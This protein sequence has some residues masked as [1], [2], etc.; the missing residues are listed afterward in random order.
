MKYLFN[1]SFIFCFTS[2]L[3]QSRDSLTFD[4]YNSSVKLYAIG[5]DHFEDDVQLQISIIEYLQKNTTIDVFIFEYSVEVGAIFNEYVLYGNKKEKVDEICSLLHENVS[6]KTKILL[7]FLK[8]YNLSSSHKI[9]VRG[10]DMFRFYELKRQMSGLLLIFPELSQINLPAV[11]RYVVKQ[12]VRNYNRKKSS[13]LINTLITEIEQHRSLYYQYLGKKMVD[14]EECL[15]DLKFYY[16]DYSWRKSDSIREAFMSQ[17]LINIVDSNS[18]SV[19]ICGGAHAMFKENDSWYY[20][21]P[22]SS[23]VAVA[24]GK[25]PNQVYSII[26]QYYEKKLYR[27]FPEFNLL[28]NPLEE[29]FED[30]SKKYEVI[31][32]EELDKHPEAKERC[33]MVIVQNKRHKETKRRK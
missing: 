24:K 28:S 17:K 25:Y 30:R 14:Y 19:L 1:I 16:M 27:F 18:V 23:M 29:Y 8:N 31:S 20:G 10:L 33:D 7:D 2:L 21:Y 32:G 13:V 15:N 12:K 11:D 4:F 6:R 9:E 26:T 22:Y 3:S 5:E